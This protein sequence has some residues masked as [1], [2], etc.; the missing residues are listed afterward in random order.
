VRFTQNLFEE[1]G[2]T[3]L[4]VE[5][6]HKIVSWDGRQIDLQ[7]WD[8]AGQ[9]RFRSV[10]RGYYRGSIGVFLVYDVTARDSFDHIKSW[11][12]EVRA[13]AH[14]NV[15]PVLIGNKSDL[16]HIR[17]VPK[18]LGEKLA[19]ELGAGFFEVSAKT[20]ENVDAALMSILGSIVQ[21]IDEG[22]YDGRIGLDSFVFGKDGTEETKPSNCC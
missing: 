6:M 17:R 19:A 16:Q 13:A 4:G 22:K 2:A 5:F 3:T 11:L 12:E 9:E 10:A 20:G 14:P 1:I 7:L 8:T 18:E 15:V 21:L